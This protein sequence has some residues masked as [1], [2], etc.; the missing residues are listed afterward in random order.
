ANGGIAVTTSNADARDLHP[1]RLTPRRDLKLLI[2]GEFY[3]K[4]RPYYEQI[5][6]LGIREQV[7]LR[8]GFIPD[9]EVPFYLCSVD[10]VIQPYRNATQS[11]V[12]PLAYHFKK[13]MIVTNVGGLPAM[14][15][16]ERSGLVAEPDP[17]SIARAIL[18]FYELGEEYFTTHL[19]LE[20]EKYSWTVMVNTIVQLAKTLHE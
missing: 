6:K 14:V 20:N 12:T 9:N 16:H 3:E 7:I 2:A 15:S 19:G 17:A 18:K 8:T 10:A 13:P 1:D 4:E 11:G 5:D